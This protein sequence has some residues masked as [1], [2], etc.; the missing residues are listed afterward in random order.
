MEKQ[1]SLKSSKAILNAFKNKF[2]TK[3]N[4]IYINSLKREVNFREVSVNEQKTLSK[5]T[6]ENESRKDIIYDSQCALINRLCLENDDGS[7][8][9]EARLAAKAALPDAIK[10]EGIDLQ[11]PAGAQFV[12]KFTN[13]FTKKYIGEHSF[14]IYYLTEFD[15]MRILMEIYQNN[16]IPEE[17]TYK[18]Q[19]CGFENKYKPDF[20]K[21]LAKL[22]E[23]DLSDKTHT[24]EDSKMIYIFTVNYPVVKNVSEFYKSYMKKYKGVTTKERDVLDNIGNIDYINLYIKKIEIVDK[25][26]G[27]REIA[28]MSYLSYDDMNELISMFPQ[29]IIFDDEKGLPKFVAKEFLDN[30]SSIFQYEKCA[31]C[32]TEAPIGIGSMAD[33]L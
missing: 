4:P 18:C 3:V 5:I 27:E 14:D 23:F 9:E 13:E 6:I 19:S 15:R 25:A 22:N 26:T 16:Y 8:K 7:L 10:A 1:E 31:Q 2:A 17:I 11:T 20:S 33:F 29:E 12:T 21:T 28:D 24:I 30:I 32:G